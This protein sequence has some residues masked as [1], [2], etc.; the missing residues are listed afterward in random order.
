MT[1]G[2]STKRQFLVDT[3]GI[4][5]ENVFNSRDLSFA[6]GLMRLTKGKGIDVVLNSLAGESLRKTWEC[7]AMFGRFIQLG[8]KDALENSGL[9]MCHFLRNVT[10]TS[11]NLEVRRFSAFHAL[12]LTM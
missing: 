10:F 7:T 1:A 8:R 11:I 12:L 9:E 6:K 4:P 5:A 2:S 3:Y